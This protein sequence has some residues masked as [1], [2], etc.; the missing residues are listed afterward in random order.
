MAFV[1]EDK[2]KELS[3]QYRCVACKNHH[4]GI[5]Q[6]FH[7]IHQET[8]GVCRIEKVGGKPSKFKKATLEEFK[9]NLLRP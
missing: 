2:Y 3:E 4:S 7:G 1:V 9:R 8:C 5:Y 6:D